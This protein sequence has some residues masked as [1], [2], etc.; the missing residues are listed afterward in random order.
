MLLL[1]PFVVKLILPLT[2]CTSVI[3][4]VLITLLPFI[5]V[6]KVITS[7][8]LSTA[9]SSISLSIIRSDCTKV[10][11]IESDSTVRGIKPK[12]F[13]IPLDL[14]TEKAKIVII[15]ANTSTTHDSTDTKPFKT[16]FIPLSLCIFN[17]LKVHTKLHCAAD[18]I[19]NAVRV[20]SLQPHNHGVLILSPWL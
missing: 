9:I 20:V 11:A 3:R 4:W 13:E 14:S 10:G 8:S 2:R 5:I 15:R 6:Q 7:P 16:F 18:Y 19:V 1:S 17:N 12:R